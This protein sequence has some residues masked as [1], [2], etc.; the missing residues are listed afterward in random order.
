MVLDLSPFLD[1]EHRAKW[2]KIGIVGSRGF[3]STYGGFETFVR[4]LAPYAVRDGHEVTVYGRGGRPAL[5][6]IDGVRVL[7]VRGADTKTASTPTHGLAAI[8]DAR[9]RNFDVA[10]VLNPANGPYLPLLPCPSVVNP[11]GLEWRRGKWG[12]LGRG[13]FFVGALA[14]ARYATE[15]VV[16]SEAI[17]RYWQRAFQ[18]ES[19]YIP[20]G[21]EV[22]SGHS[23]KR[24]A[25]LGLRP[26]G[27]ALVVARLVPENNVEM[28]VDAFVESNINHRLVVVGDANYNS[29]TVRHLHQ[30]SMS[31]QRIRRLGHVDNQ[32]LLADLWG[33]AGLYIHGHSV[34]GTNPALL[35]AMGHGAGVIA[36][37]S[38]FNREVLRGESWLFSDAK[39]LSE[40]WR[41]V[42]EDPHM[43]KQWQED[44]Q[45]RIAKNY[46]WDDVCARYLSTLAKA[47][48]RRPRPPR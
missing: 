8:L 43:L 23:T 32:E 15:V 13:A 41:R 6:W 9:R 7:N 10:L 37:R 29:P 48:G 45:E 39:E 21:A 27:Y 40:I 28:I 46:A 11:D 24:I 20:Y 30:A 17:G 22:V 5:N 42:L 12:R 3:P 38:P 19:T 16:D 47:A 35:Q 4:H 26:G 36:F 33:N 25:D 1:V 14:V 44:C 18:R 2:M 31:N 34:G